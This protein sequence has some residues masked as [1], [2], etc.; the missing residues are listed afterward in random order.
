MMTNKKVQEEL[1]N[2]NYI[3]HNQKRIVLKYEEEIRKK[4]SLFFNFAFSYSS[5]VFLFFVIFIIIISLLIGNFFYFFFGRT[6]K[7]EIT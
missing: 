7:Q 6:S 1:Y 4:E 2:D 5:L 3:F